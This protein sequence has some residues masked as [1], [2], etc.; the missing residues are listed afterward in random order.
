MSSAVKLAPVVP[1]TY[2]DPADYERFFTEDERLKTIETKFVIPRETPAIGQPGRSCE[3]NLFFGFFFD[4]TRN[5]YGLSEQRG[6]HTHSN[7]ARLFEAYPGQTIAPRSAITARALWPNE[8][9]YPNYFRVYLPGVGTPFEEIDDSGAGLDEKLGSAFARWGER[10]I[11]WA[12]AQAINAVH[13]YFHKRALVSHAEVVEWSQQVDLDRRGLRD[14]P[15]LVWPD[16]AGGDVP[17]TMARL[18]Q[19]LQRLHQALAVHMPDARTGQPLRVDPGIVRT[20]YVSAFG[21]SRGA[22]MARAF[23]NWFVALCELDA[24]MLGRSGRTLGGFPVEF[25]FLGLFDTVASVGLASTALVGNGHGAWAD[26]EV[27]LR[28]PAGI[29]CTHLVAAHEVRRSFPLDSIS[30]GGVVSEGCQEIVFPGVHSDVGG[31]Y[32]PGEQGRGSDPLGADLLSRIALAIMYREA[33]L[34][35]V[36]FRL[37]QARSFVKD[38][39]RIAPSTIAAF[40]AYIEASERYAQGHARPGMPPLRA[41]M[42]T[43]MELAILWRRRWAG[44]LGEMPV[45]ARARQEDRNDL[46]SADE[47]FVQEIRRFER[48]RQERRRTADPCSDVVLGTCMQ[49]E[50]RQVPG[51]DSGRFDE[52][53]DMAQWWDRSEVPEAVAVLFETLVHDS[54]AWFKLRG[55]EAAQVERGL[56]RWA[57]EYEEYLARTEQARRNGEPVPLA[58]FDREELSWIR[59]YKA[60]GQVPPMKTRGREPFLLGAGY[61]RFRRIYAGGDRL[62][63]TQTP[64]AWKV[65]A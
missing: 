58:P 17:H 54:R 44:R 25:D 56:Q 42:R 29:K 49:A 6:D 1:E 35:G 20:L 21:F 38:R 19:V 5:H 46:L 23:A 52:W 36:P 62:R 9:A 16:A 53:E 12:L 47:E 33:R 43:Q 55:W 32:A 40:N 57:R 51:L 15:R 60:T 14:L 39:F 61:L 22:A 2:E 48:W 10:R 65:A 7:V 4:G 41:L 37:E 30:V 64:P 59:A 63:L 28:I 24:R 8:A 13:R 34:Q 18:Q 31:G 26:A 45:L 50:Q 27:S 11:L 3:T